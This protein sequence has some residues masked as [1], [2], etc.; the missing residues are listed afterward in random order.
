MRPLKKT[1]P[2]Q[3]LI[4]WHTN[5]KNE[6][7]SPSGG[8]TRQLHLQPMHW[9]EELAAMLKA[10]WLARCYSFNHLK[11][12][13]FYYSEASNQLCHFTQIVHILKKKQVSHQTHEGLNQRGQS[14]ILSMNFLNAVWRS[15]CRMWTFLMWQLQ[16][17]RNAPAYQW[18]DH[19]TGGS[20]IDEDACCPWW[21]ELTCGRLTAGTASN[22]LS[23][24]A[25]D[26]LHHTA[27]TVSQPLS[28]LTSGTVY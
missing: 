7:L 17:L 23:K 8:G 13:I 12:Q 1:H 9:P 15:S 22:C 25:F 28:Q 11:L 20:I 27:R 5:M 2:S 19:Q 6:S 3:I 14:L 24:V 21:S 4:I 16:G 18:S 10:P 26:Q